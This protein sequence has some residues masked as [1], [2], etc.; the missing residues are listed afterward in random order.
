ME[1]FKRVKCLLLL[2]SLA[3]PGTGQAAVESVHGNTLSLAEAVTRAQDAD[4]WLQGSLLQQQALMAQSVSAG[5][6]PDPM[7]SLGLANLPTDTFDFNQEAMTQFKVGVSQRFARGDSLALERE[8]LALLGS[9]HPE[10][11]EDR[12]ARVAVIVAGLWLDSYRATETIR[13]IEEDRSLFEYLVEVAQSSYATALGK[14]R[15]QDIIRAQLELTRLE[16]RLASLHQQRDSA[17][18]KLGE[19]LG[20]S[21]PSG[22]QLSWQQASMSQAF[23]IA[24]SLKPLPLI[25]SAIL[26]S[27]AP[28]DE[29]WLSQYLL[30]HPAVRSLENKIEVERSGVA[31]AEQK[32][33]PQWGVNASYGYRDD[34]PAGSDRSDFFSVG[35]TFDL[36]LFTANRQDKGVQSA[37]AKTEAVRTEKW[38]LLR[39]MRAEV[40][41]QRARLFRLN[42]RR[43]LY[44]NQL[45]AQM[46]DQAEASLSAYTTDDGDF[47]EVVRARIAELNARIDALDIEIERAKT[48]A[49]LNYFFV[50]HA[51][52]EAVESGESS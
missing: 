16:D 25:E 5:S 52:S 4:P 14:T 36:P 10:M 6:L 22:G 48:V 35:V 19:W 7:V 51:S 26:Q 43:D 50:G 2:A 39:G 47:S 18:G 33:K 31:I 17:N 41:T 8:R 24:K 15:Q 34:E 44:S 20:P 32:Y 38:L 29:Q 1:L 49:Q 28:L 9:R 30:H 13:L 21:Y 3:L 37:V 12:R 27:Q 11:R 46:R 40:E 45:L 23:A 42:Q